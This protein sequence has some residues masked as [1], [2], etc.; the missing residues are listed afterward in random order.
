[1]EKIAIAI[2]GGAG[3]DSGYIRENNKEYREGLE[4]AVRAGYEILEKN[5]SAVDAVEAAVRELEDNPLFNSGRGSALNARG[6]VQ[7]CTSIMDGET[8]NSGAAALIRNIK[9]PVSF[10]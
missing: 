6:E 8:L 2:H 10:A 4:K 1:M 5:G 7:M 9:N 3:K